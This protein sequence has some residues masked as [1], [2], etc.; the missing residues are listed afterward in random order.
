MKITAEYLILVKCFIGFVREKERNRE[1]NW[2]SG[3]AE[4]NRKSNKEWN[5]KIIQY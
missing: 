3:M 1:R 5:G 2:S 4:K